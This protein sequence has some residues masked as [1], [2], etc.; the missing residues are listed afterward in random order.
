MLS[1]SGNGLDSILN[2]LQRILGFAS[3][4][5]GLFLGVKTLRGEQKKRRAAAKAAGKEQEKPKRKNPL[6]VT[7]RP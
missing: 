1:V 6:R 5:V 3:T 4:L 7:S 2:F